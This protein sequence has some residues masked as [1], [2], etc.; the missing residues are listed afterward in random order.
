[1]DVMPVA[2]APVKSRLAAVLQQV[3]DSGS[4]GITLETVRIIPKSGGEDSLSVDI[5]PISGDPGHHAGAVLTLRRYARQQGRYP[6]LMEGEGANEFLS[7]VGKIAHDVNNS[8]SSVLA[9]IQLVRFGMDE[10]SDGDQ[11]LDRA[12][13]SVLQARDLCDQLLALSVGQEAKLPAA[14]AAGRKKRRGA[15][16]RKEQPPAR[17]APVKKKAAKKKILLMDDDEAILSATSEMLKFLG[18]DVTVAEN[19][20]VALERYEKAQKGGLPFDAVVLDITVPGGPGAVE[21]L[22]LLQ[23]IDPGVR[24]I[25]SS[26]Y[27]TNPVIVNFASYGFT[28]VIVKP[29]GFREL[30]EA[31]DTAFKS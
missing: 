16:P 13:E 17:I 24:A 11:W 5:A 29:Y 14:G 15:R 21:T 9:N 27:S 10:Q 19:G 12:E 26:G 20:N 25:V 23:K 8:L 31:L 2:E 4:A 22:P 1:M 7:L 3:I 18:Y 28:A 30:G 6:E